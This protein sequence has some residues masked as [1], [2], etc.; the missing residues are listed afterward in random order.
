MAELD[1][2]VA[3]AVDL[4]RQQRTFEPEID[5]VRVV[6]IDVELVV[7]EKEESAENGA[8]ADANSDCCMMID[9]SVVVAV[10]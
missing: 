3:V 8:D 1:I 2:A 9:E 10:D 4:I 7:E 5:L 6:D